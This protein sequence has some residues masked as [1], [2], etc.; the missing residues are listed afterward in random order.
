MARPEFDL[1]RVDPDAGEHR[2]VAVD[3]AEVSESGEDHRPLLFAAILADR[4]RHRPAVVQRDRARTVFPRFRQFA[5]VAERFQILFKQVQDVGD[6]LS[7]HRR[8][9]RVEEFFPVAGGAF[10]PLL[11]QRQMPVEHRE[12]RGN[13]GRI[14]TVAVKLGELLLQQVQPGAEFRHGFALLLV[15]VGF[16]GV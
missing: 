16:D 14:R 2:H 15:E 6:F 5:A 11:Q 13:V 1:D 3:V 8:L 12:R 10:Q 4:F 9:F 7:G